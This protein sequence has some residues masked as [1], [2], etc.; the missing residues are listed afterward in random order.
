[1][2][3]IKKDEYELEYKDEY[4]W[5][6]ETQTENLFKTLFSVQDGDDNQATLENGRS[7]N[8]FGRPNP[9]TY[10]LVFRRGTLTIE[11][12]SDDDDTFIQRQMNL[13]FQS[14]LAKR[15]YNLLQDRVVGAEEAGNVSSVGRGRDDNNSNGRS[16]VDDESLLVAFQ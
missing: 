8:I 9:Y 14:L 13:W 5:F 11:I 3:R 16:R 10:Q 12:S 1:M 2:L 4:C 6:I 15:P 7:N